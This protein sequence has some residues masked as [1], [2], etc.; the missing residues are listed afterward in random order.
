MSRA[1]ARALVDR[2]ALIDGEPAAP[3]QRVGAGAVI[4]VAVPEK[5]EDVTLPADPVD[6]TV[7]HEDRDVIVVDKPA[8]LVVHPGGSRTTRSLASG[9]LQR[10]PE[11]RGVGVEGRWG[12]VHR[13]DKDTS[14]LLLVAR[15]QNA[16]DDLTAKL[17]RREII[18]SYIAL[19]HGLIGSPTGTIDAP[20]GSDPARPMRR[21]LAPD[22]R[23]AR[24]HFQ[25]EATFPGE[26]CTLVRVGLE[27]G[28][29]HQIR[30][31]F[32]AIGHPVV[33]DVWY[34]HQPR[35][36]TSPRLFLHAFEVSLEHPATGEQVTFTSDLPAG[37]VGVLEAMR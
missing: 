13:L 33:G 35:R 36:A 28:R 9:L 8:G 17:R 34:G 1:A 5:D 21:M 27:T 31:H 20:I 6:F 26:D 7:V 3:S 12:L 23:P 16:Y 18:R 11:L 32:A 14:G 25:V 4:T 2:G 19:V 30:V 10:Y 37:L 29:T 15:N 24:T 22:G